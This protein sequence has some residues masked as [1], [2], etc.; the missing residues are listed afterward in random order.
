MTG[1]RF[2][3]RAYIDICHGTKRCHRRG[4]GDPLG[5]DVMW[6][7][8]FAASQKMSSSPDSLT[9]GNDDKH[10]VIPAKPE[11]PLRASPRFYARQE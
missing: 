3:E 9:G 4:W 1:L 5:I 11:S 8:S 6:V 2:T 10:R 7:T